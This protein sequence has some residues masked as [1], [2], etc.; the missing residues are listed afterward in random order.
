MIRVIIVCFLLTSCIRINHSPP[1]QYKKEIQH[2]VLLWQKESQNKEIT[3]KLLNSLENLKIIPQ[4]QE[5]K[6]GTVITSK[7]TIVDDSYDI[8]L[9]VTFSSEE[10][11]QQY[12]DHPL[13]KQIVRDD[14]KPNISKILVYDFYTN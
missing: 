9:I 7:R 13:H 2:L 10:N 14:I 6:V 4:V 11:M 8:G 1:K 12:I 5:L 3:N